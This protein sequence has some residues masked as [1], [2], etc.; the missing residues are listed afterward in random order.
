MIGGTKLQQFVWFV[1]PTLVLRGA[2]IAAVFGV[3]FYAGR[4]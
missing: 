2:L 4:M 1:L 3:G